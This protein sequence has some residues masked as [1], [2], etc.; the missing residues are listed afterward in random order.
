MA[1][2][3]CLLSPLVYS[4]L[5]RLLAADERMTA[6]LAGRL[7]QIDRPIEWLDYLRDIYD[8]KWAEDREQIIKGEWAPTGM[9]SDHAILASWILVGLRP[10]GELSDFGAQ[11]NT[12]VSERLSEEAPNLLTR[13]GEVFSPAIVAWTLGMVVDAGLSSNLPVV[14]AKP[15]KHIQIAA[16]YDGLIKHV[17]I[18]GMTPAPWPE[19]LGTATLVRGAGLVEA[20]R[21]APE[22]KVWG[23]L[24][25]VTKLIQ[26]A[27][28]AMVEGLR[29]RVR[30][31]WLNGDFIARRNTIVHIQGISGEPSFVDISATA[32]S[33]EKVEM[34]I[35]GLTQFVFHEVSV[36]LEDGRTIQPY[37]IDNILQDLIV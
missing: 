35:R 12:A 23:P 11:L 25:A 28:G 19:M 30:E 13:R 22:G 10:L 27:E 17:K 1:E 37:F 24:Q 33:W 20:L 32:N 21:P 7:G 2:L 31:H 6:N 34:T 36:E 29:K 4:Q 5:Y 8:L 3:E 9:P 26:E 15:I 18:L 16:A 14:P